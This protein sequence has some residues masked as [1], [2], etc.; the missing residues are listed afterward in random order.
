MSDDN[1]IFNSDLIDFNLPALLLECCD[2]CLTHLFV[3]RMVDNVPQLQVYRDENATDEARRVM[4]KKERKKIVE[5]FGGTI[6]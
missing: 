6:D 2:C 5:L 1:Q 3:L 4:K